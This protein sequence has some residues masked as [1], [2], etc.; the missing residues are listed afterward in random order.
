PPLFAFQAPDGVAH[1]V[2][3]VEPALT[4]ALVEAFAALPALYIADGHHRAAAAA[5]ARAALGRGGGADW[6]LA[7]AFPHD[8]VRILPYNRVV[9]DLAGRTPEAFLAALGAALPVAEGA[10]SPPARGRC[11]MYLAGRWY[12]IDLTAGRGAEREDEGAFDVERLQA[13]VLGPLLDV[14]DPRSDPRLEFVSGAGGSAA[15]E[16]IVDA[17]RAA[18]AFAMY[19]VGVEDLMRVADAGGILPP[20]STWFEPKLRDGLLV[21]LV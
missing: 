4:A 1:T 2:W 12:T 14:A 21:H 19:P 7:V 15:L 5:R 16:A 10:P 11:G 17:G 13:Q 20:K 8:E 18:V 6:F 3:R 9:R